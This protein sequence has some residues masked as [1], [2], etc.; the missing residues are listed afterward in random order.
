MQ[1]AQAVEVDWE[2]LQNY[3]GGKVTLANDN[4]VLSLVRGKAV[5]IRKV[6]EEWVEITMTCDEHALG[7]LDTLDQAVWVRL[8]GSKAPAILLA[9][10]EIDDEGNLQ[11]L[12]RTPQGSVALI[13]RP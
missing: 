8:D 10:W 2:V 12:E 5:E 11:L 9:P 7:T 3:V 4:S 6:G 13:E 1:L